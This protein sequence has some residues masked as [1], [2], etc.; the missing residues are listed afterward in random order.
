MISAIIIDDRE[1]REHPEY[2]LL[3]PVASVSRLDHGDFLV[4]TSDNQMLV[5]EHKTVSGLCQDIADGRLFNQCAGLAK[6]R[7]Q[8]MWPYLLIDSPLIVEQG[9]GSLVMNYKTTGWNF[10]AVQGALITIQEMGIMIIHANGEAD[11]APTVE[12]LARRE[13]GELHIHPARTPRIL[14][15]G[16]SVLASLPGVGWEKTRALLDYCKTPAWAIS[17]LTRLGENG[18]P[19]IGDGIKRSIRRALELEEGTELWPISKVE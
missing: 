7:E 5:V 9:T 17:Y 15:A 1:D 3:F 18:V 16:E 12:R 13:R 11:I 10:G 8:G 6:L 4:A 19:G 2:K 14:S